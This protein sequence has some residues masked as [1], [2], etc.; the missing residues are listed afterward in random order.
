M[1]SDLIKKGYEHAPHRALLRAMGVKE[2][3]F[4]KPFIAVAN[5]YTDIVAGHV[6]LK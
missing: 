2:E 5:Y 4:N 1:R 6:Q 3:D